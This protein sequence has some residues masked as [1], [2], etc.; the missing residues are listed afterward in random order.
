[1]LLLERAK[2]KTSPWVQNTNPEKSSKYSDYP[3]KLRPF[4][5]SGELIQET[6]RSSSPVKYNKCDIYL[7]GQTKTQVIESWLLRYQIRKED[8]LLL[9][10]EKVL[11]V[12][13][14]QS[15]L[16]KNKHQKVK[17]ITRYEINYLLRQAELEN[18]F[19][20][21]ANQWRSETKH[22]SLMSDIVL[23]SAYQRIIGMGKDAVPLILEE[24]SRKPDHWFWALRCIT[25][26]NPI[27]PED[28]GRVKKM[29]QAWLNW[30]RQHGYKC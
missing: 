4:C 17:S 16:Q 7:S 29:A 1:M 22:M 9:P 24:L 12:F 11:N 30:S 15:L 14:K 2:D 19:M 13:S 18:S 20:K 27:K 5:E 25:G 28:R 10:E 6:S 21:L 3:K 26:V 8:I 23:H